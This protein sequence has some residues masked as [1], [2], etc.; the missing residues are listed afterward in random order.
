MPNPT[1]LVIIG[2]GG[3]GR[4]TLDIV[5]AINKVHTQWDFLGFLADGE[6]RPDLSAKRN[7]R[8]LGGVDL[9]GELDAHYVIGIGL[10]DAR[11]EIEQQADRLRRQ[12]ATLVHPS[13]ILGS[14]VRL[15][16]GCCVAAGSILTTNIVVGRHTH[17]DIGVTVSHDVTINNWCTIAPGVSVAGWVRIEDGATIGVGAILR[18]RIT[19][20][21]YAVVGAG[22]VVIDDVPAGATVAGVPAKPIRSHSI[23]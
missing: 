5:E 23:S 2:A 10:G 8:I 1:P 19:I 3:H 11:K 17:I 22:S 9:L 21:E 18:D 4:E 7:A 16:V 20:G 14:E 13:V 15:G 12:A 6:K